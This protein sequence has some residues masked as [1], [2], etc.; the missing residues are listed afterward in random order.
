M[1][2]LKSPLSRVSRSS[3]QTTTLATSSASTSA[4]SSRIAG[5]SGVLPDTRFLA[6]SMA[7]QIL[8][9]RLLTQLRLHP[10]SYTLCWARIQSPTP[11][12]NEA[13]VALQANSKDWFE[14]AQILEKELR[15]S[16]EYTFFPSEITQTR[17][18]IIQGYEQHVKASATAHSDELAGWV[19]QEALWHQVSLAPTDALALAR[20][21]LSELDAVEINRAWR[22]YWEKHRAQIFGYGF[23]PLANGTDLIADAYGRSS[24]EKLFAPTPPP[25]GTFAYTDFG[26]LGRLVRRRH[27]AAADMYLLEF[28]NGIRL[29]T[30]K[31][32]RRVQH[33]HAL[34]PEALAVMGD[35]IRQGLR[36][37]G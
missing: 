2:R 37:H 36:P 13:S 3:R 31:V 4:I 1:R 24:R 28:A 29:R 14:A 20:T 25:S 22:S 18:R 30:G 7:T 6:G 16:F 26:P 17:S 8:Q 35:E 19:M 15:Q 27:E 21:T 10:K 5:R 33:R 32:V 11:F 12:S 9:E 34:D 23:F